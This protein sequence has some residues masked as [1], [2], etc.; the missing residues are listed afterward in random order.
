LRAKIQFD[1]NNG[2]M[3]DPTIF[4]TNLVPHAQTKTA[5]KAYPTY[6]LVRGAVLRDWSV[7]GFIRFARVVRVVC[8]RCACGLFA[9]CI[10]CP[11]WLHAACV[12]GACGVLGMC[13][14]VK[15]GGKGFVCLVS[16]F[17]RDCSVV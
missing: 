5:Y 7:C 3:R 2:S 11:C 1:S 14:Q 10:R 17:D 8:V 13:V 4:R 12:Q 16:S 15:I 6:D 9:I